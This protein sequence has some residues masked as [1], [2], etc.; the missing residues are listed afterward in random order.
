VNVD[1]ETMFDCFIVK[2]YEQEKNNLFLKNIE[3]DLDSSK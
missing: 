3:I 1:K 2:K